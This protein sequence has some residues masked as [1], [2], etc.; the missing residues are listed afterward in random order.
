MSRLQWV[1]RV[2][3]PAAF[4]GASIPLLDLLREAFLGGDLGP[5]PVRHIQ[6]VTG[7]AC[8]ALLLA[9]LTIT[10]LRRYLH[11]GQLIKLRRMLGLWAFTYA[12]L[13]FLTYLIFDQSLDVSRIMADTVKHPRIYVGFAAFLIL[14]ALALTSTDASVRRLGKR[15]VTLH[16]WIYLAVLFGIIHFAM[17]Q[18]LDYRIPLVWG[19][20]FL[21]LMLSRI[22]RRASQR[23]P[24]VAAHGVV[25]AASGD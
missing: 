2:V 7:I 24:P 8:L 4:L 9:T 16:R 1:T 11:L 14:L 25:S 3:K 21:V 22:R 12:S 23:P 20:G 19:A 18:K 17:V 13:H 5:D 6:H 15:W 10:P